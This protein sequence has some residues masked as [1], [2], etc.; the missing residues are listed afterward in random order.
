MS[1]PTLL[2]TILKLSPLQTAVNSNYITVPIIYKK[3]TRNNF[4]I[5]MHAKDWT[6][7]LQVYPI[8]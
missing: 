4:S 6:S 8:Q 7:I 3:V 5:I 1:C 2:G